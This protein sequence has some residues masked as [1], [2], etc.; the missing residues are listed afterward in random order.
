MSK[1]SSS[2]SACRS[3]SSA[4]RAGIVKIVKSWGSASS[5]SSQRTGA[6]TLASGRPRT[7]YAAA[8]VWSRA[9]WL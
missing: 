6:E 8:M 1:T 9:F 7:E 4:Y 3:P 5:T 2:M